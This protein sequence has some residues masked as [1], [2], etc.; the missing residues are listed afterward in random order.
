[1][2]TVDRVATPQ[3]VVQKHRST[4]YFCDSLGGLSGTAA[5]FYT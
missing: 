4:S 1:M 3:K 5:A 2:S